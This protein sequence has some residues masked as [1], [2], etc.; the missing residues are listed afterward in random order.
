MPPR[1]PAP[2]IRSPLRVGSIGPPRR[3]LGV[4][5]GRWGLALGALGVVAILYII[6][7][8]SSNGHGAKTPVAGKVLDTTTTLVAPTST[9]APPTSV[10]ATLRAAALPA[11]LSRT[12][13][14]A[15]GSTALVF[16]GRTNQKTS[17][18][19]VLRF[20]P[21]TSS[22]AALGTL[23]EVLHDAAGVTVAGKAL[24]VGGG[25]VKSS[26]AVH[27][28]V[29][30]K[31]T[32]TGHLPEPRADVQ[33]AAIGSTMY[34]VGGYDGAREPI[35]VLASDDGGATFRVVASLLNGNRYGMLVAADKMLYLIGG[36]ENA[37]QVAKIL[38]IDPAS[39]A[40][41]QIGQLPAPLSNA[42]V[43]VLNGSVFVAGGRLGANATDQILRVDLVSGTASPAGTLPEPV[44]NASAAV[45]GDT[46]YL[47]GGEAAAAKTNV[48]A[49]TANR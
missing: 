17:V 16:G 28:V 23:S 47:F 44:A 33:A 45:I 38:R 1:R 25:D 21:T 43:F 11:P 14:T 36:E 30:T 10:V 2:P 8:V 39:G 18:N 4:P 37:K 29:D 49:I 35:T 26:S 42:S 7:L 6:G 9:L 3:R 15:D 40:V 5:G 22:F 46:A 48:V 31:V 27:L 19:Q 32:V 34:V 41:A 20:D 24:M 13:A 12:A